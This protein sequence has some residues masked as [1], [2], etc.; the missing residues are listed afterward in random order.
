MGIYPERV[1]NFGIMEQSMIGFAAGLASA[2]MYPMVYSITPFLVDRG[3]EQIK[4]DLVYN[5]SKALILSAGASY[6][7]SSLGPSHHC[8]HDISCLLNIGFPLLIHPYTDAEAVKACESIVRSHCLAYLRISSTEWK[9][10]SSNYRLL[11]TFESSNIPGLV[12]LHVYE[13]LL[14]P[15]VSLTSRATVMFGPD[16]QYFEQLNDSLSSSRFAI[17]LSVISSESLSR[18]SKILLEFEECDLY[19][20]YDCS[21]IISRLLIF[22]TSTRRPILR[23]FT[24]SAGTYYDS[25]Y[26]KNKIFHLATFSFI[27]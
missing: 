18:L 27:V 6:D 25:S 12:E 16:S 24:T 26:T 20:P 19:I 2:G 1:I 13:N 3:F 15:N 21:A 9:F 23:I 8:P 4:L 5:K 10:D 17:Q 7:Y 22:T 14:A 11:N